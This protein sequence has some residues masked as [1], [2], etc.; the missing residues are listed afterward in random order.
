MNKCPRCKNEFTQNK[1]GTQIYC[2]E[3]CRK[4]I[5]KLR[6]KERTAPARAIKYAAWLADNQPKWEAIQAAKEE[7]RRLRREARIA[8]RKLPRVRKRKTLL[9]R[10]ENYMPEPNTGC[11]FWLGQLSKKN[12]Y[13]EVFAEGKRRNAC[14]VAYAAWVGPIPEGKMICHHCD[15][16]AC[17]NPD[18]L[19]AGT[20][21]TNYDDM[22]RRGRHRVNTVGLKAYNEAKKKPKPSAW[23]RKRYAGMGI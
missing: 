12:G 22:V 14:R 20:A 8:A 18:H 7:A 15:N 13:A 16:P 17:I 23:G 10:L 6:A 11:W 19:Y 2:T 1:R 4:K 3:Y 5:E 21:R 9:E